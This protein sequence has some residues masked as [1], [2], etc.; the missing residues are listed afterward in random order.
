MIHGTKRLSLLIEASKKRT[1]IA[2]AFICLPS[3]SA[4][5]ENTDRAVQRNPDQVL[6]VCNSN[7]P[8]SK[9]IAGDY[10]KKRHIQN[11][12]WRFG[13]RIQH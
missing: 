4:H 7:S 9:A 3:A 11:V 13:V 5:A 10:A 8:T 1:L 12:L 6:L 2:L